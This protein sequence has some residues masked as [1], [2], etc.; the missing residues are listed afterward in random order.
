M[1]DSR[2]KVFLGVVQAVIVLTVRI[3]VA[4]NHPVTIEDYWGRATLTVVEVADGISRL[5]HSELS[6]T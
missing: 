2:A 3:A 1:K 4:N 5:N 6:L